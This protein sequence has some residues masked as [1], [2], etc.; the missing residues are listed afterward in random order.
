MKTT[1]A[2]TSPVKGLLRA[3][4]I[5]AGLLVAGQSAL[6]A[7]TWTKITANAPGAVNLMILLPN[8]TV[9][10]ANSSAVTNQWYKLTPSSTGSY[11]AGTWSTLAPAFDTR[12]YFQTQ[13][14][15]D[16]RV[17]VS[18]GEYGTGG[19][20]SEI[21]NP[22]TNTWAHNPIPAGLW[23]P[24]I[25]SNDFYDGNS[26]ILT[27]GSVL[28]M[29]VFPKT[30]GIGLR[31]NPTTNVWTNAGKLF[32]GTY[33]DE[34]SWV[35]LPDNSI[36][37]IDPFG[38]LSE[39]Y[40]PSTNTWIN[41]GVVPV[42]LYDPFGFE[43]GGATYLPNGKVIF[44]GSTGNTALYTPTGTNAPGTWV[45]GPVIP[46]AHGTPDAPS[47]MEVDGKLLCAVSPIPTS[48]NHFPAP[49]TFYEYDYTTNAFTTV[50][51]P[52]ASEASLSC[53]QAMMLCLPNGQIMYS[54]MGTDCYVYTPAGAPLAAAKPTVSSVTKNV[55]GTF[56]L[57]GTLLNGINEGATYGDDW[58]MNTNRPLVRITNLTSGVVTYARTF[59]WSSTA[60]ATGATPLTT[61]YTHSLGAGNYSY[62][63][64][65]NGVASDPFC[66]TPV[67]TTNP[68]PKSTC[69]GGSAVFTAAGTGTSLTYQWR[70][71]VTNL[72]NGGH[73][74]G[75]TTPTLTISSANAADAASYNCVITNG[76]ATGSATTT[77]AALTLCLV[78]FNCDGFATGED[79]DAYVAAFEA[80][81]ISADFDGNGFVT[82]EDFDA[83]VAAFELGC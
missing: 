47:A 38:T 55:D 28:I 82:G 35:K 76:C 56:H 45:A 2:R 61:E 32:R 40:I 60:I 20:N 24:A 30:A 4:A 58:Q 54:H 53:Y 57:T 46:G 12:L 31:Y 69:L 81:S 65:A 39:R 37:T 42:S 17:Y 19:P 22:Q 73:I 6:A 10:C 25:G 14:L 33:Q 36:L 49:T 11:V 8:G 80:G 21:Y 78:D 16:G 62:V 51:T 79:F 68:L 48:A 7:G 29:P 74:S 63:V 5:T 9:M 50:P 26:E 72:V 27:D 83:F 15:N 43:L 44:L 1:L 34:A 71:G 59:N 13:V 52:S 70:K 18:G 64:T 3:A 66:L 41:D 23:T 67:V 75:A 77:S